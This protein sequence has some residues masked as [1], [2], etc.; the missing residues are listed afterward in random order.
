MEHHGF[1]RACKSAQEE[2]SMSEC[3]A[4]LADQTIPELQDETRARGR[5]RRSLKSFQKSR[6]LKR[7]ST[8][9]QAWLHAPRPRSAL[10]IRL[11]HRPATTRSMDH[12]GERTHDVP[13]G[14]LLQAFVF[15]LV[16]VGAFVTAR[17][18]G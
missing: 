1:A 7:R 9:S 17:A 13:L 2:S 5:A 11:Q 14:R 12:G 16:A 6:V 18:V 10:V 15:V 8:C 3:G 4:R